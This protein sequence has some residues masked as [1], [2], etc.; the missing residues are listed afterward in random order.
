MDMKRKPVG[1]I[2]AASLNSTQRSKIRGRFDRYWKKIEDFVG[3]KTVIQ[4]RSHAQKYFLK[5]QKNGTLAR[6]PP[7][8][9]KRSAAHP[10]PHKASKSGHGQLDGSSLLISPSGNMV[11]CCEEF[12]YLEAADGLEPIYIGRK[13][14]TITI[15]STSRVLPG[16]DMSKQI[17]QGPELSGLPNFAAVYSFIGSVFDPDTKDYAQKLKQMD[18]I[19]F[20]TVLMLMNNI[21]FNLLNPDFEPII[22]VLCSYDINT[23][24]EMVPLRTIAENQRNICSRINEL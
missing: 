14:L 5:I 6:V 2:T 10:Y 17:R 7:L 13:C 8:R 3:S 11:A 20:E 1:E 22:K 21:T 4:I 23:K 15:G 12:F 24:T 19:D 16:S 9:P 18:P